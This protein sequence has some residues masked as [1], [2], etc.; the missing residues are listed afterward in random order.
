MAVIFNLRQKWLSYSTCFASY[1]GCGSQPFIAV[2][3]PRTLFNCM[4]GQEGV[5][6]I[7][8]KIIPYPE[9]RAAGVLMD[10]KITQ[11][12]RKKNNDPKTR[13]K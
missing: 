4:M 11:K 5:S 3:A 9:S 1:L 2:I 8:K 6:K 7:L 13:A 12:L 10:A